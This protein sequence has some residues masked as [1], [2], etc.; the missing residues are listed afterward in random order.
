MKVHPEGSSIPN[1]SNHPPELVQPASQNI[2][3]MSGYA[4][5]SEQHH[6]PY[7]SS[8]R[9]SRDSPSRYYTDDT[10]TQLVATSYPESSQ[11]TMMHNASYLSEYDTR[12]FQSSSARNDQTTRYTHLGNSDLDCI[13]SNHISTTASHPRMPEFDVH[14]YRQDSSTAPSH[15]HF[16]YGLNTAATSDQTTHPMS[17][18][19]TYPG[20]V[21]SL[22]PATASKRRNLFMTSSLQA[23]R[24]PSYGHEDSSY[25]RS[26]TRD[27]VHL[28]NTDTVR[29]PLPL[30][31]IPMSNSPGESPASLNPSLDGF[32]CATPDR[33]PATSIASHEALDDVSSSSVSKRRRSKMHE[34]EVCGKL[35]PR[36]AC[37]E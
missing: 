17:C 10:L 16:E 36:Y 23:R 8:Q 7:I 18:E 31:S 26:R 34:C 5:A 30:P 21:A 33:D 13:P 12:D 14:H 2:L 9:P 24:R 37:I 22:A 29:L 25:S 6:P 27:S 15:H 35:F 32:P 20:R 19:Q 11:R 4:V 28:Q 1:F 3:N